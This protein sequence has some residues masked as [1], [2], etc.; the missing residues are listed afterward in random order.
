MMD[1]LARIASVMVVLTRSDFGLA[2][3]FVVP[4]VMASSVWAVNIYLQHIGGYKWKVS[5]FN[6]QLSIP[7]IF[8]NEWG[9]YE[10]VVARSV[11]STLVAIVVLLVP[12]ETSIEHSL[13]VPALPLCYGIL[14][15]LSIG[16]RSNT[17][18]MNSVSPRI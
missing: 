13:P 8:M 18:D 1:T 3:F 6:V 17:Y 11:L 12:L 7:T 14:A 5:W 9:V 16:Q 2:R 10:E 15:V 4:L